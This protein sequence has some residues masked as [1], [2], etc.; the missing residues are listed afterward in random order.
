MIHLFVIDRLG[1]GLGWG[2]N[3]GIYIQLVIAKVPEHLEIVHQ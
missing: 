1:I 3:W 2:T